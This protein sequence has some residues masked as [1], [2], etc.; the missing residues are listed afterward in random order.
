VVSHSQ[1]NLFDLT[2]SHP[3]SRRS[4]GFIVR[5]IDSLTKTSLQAPNKEAATIARV[6]TE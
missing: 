3:R 2:G 6:I 4:S 5:C 1:V